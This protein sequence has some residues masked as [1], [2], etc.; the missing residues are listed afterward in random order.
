MKKRKFDP[1]SMAPRAAP[2]LFRNKAGE[3]TTTLVQ[4]RIAGGESISFAA[5][6]NSSF[7]QSRLPE[8]F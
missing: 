7:D 5:R 8:S 6:Q 3:S 2:N 1:S 4:T